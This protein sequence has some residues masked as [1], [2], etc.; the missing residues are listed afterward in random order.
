MLDVEYL[1]AAKDNYED[2]ASGK[3]LHNARGMTAFPVRLASEIIQRCFAL[4]SERGCNAPYTVYDPCCGGG[5]L[6]TV[7]GLLHGEKVGRILASDVDVQLLPIAEKN[8]ALLTP[9]GMRARQQQIEELF[10]QHGKPSHREALEAIG[11]LLPAT[12]RTSLERAT[13]FERDMTDNGAFEPIQAHIVIA[14][15][16]YGGIAEWHSR[17]PDPLAAFFEQAS[18]V[19]DPQHAVLAVIADKTQKLQHAGWRR[20][21]YFRIGK[22]HVGIFEKQG[23]NT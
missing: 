11:R 5:Y 9:E 1:Y 8:L 17:S 3:V 6:L 19:V 22:R 14:D 23:A 12:E 20:R 10:R 21:Q 4:L 16:P 13:V 18:A 15:L 2:F 7:I